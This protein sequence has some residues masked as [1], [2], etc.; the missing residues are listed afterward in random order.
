MEAHRASRP[1]TQVHFGR[2][3][4]VPELRLHR[5]HQLRRLR[6]PR[7]RPAQHR[8]V[9]TRVPH[10]PRLL[11]SGFAESHRADG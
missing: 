9:R 4:A 6:L 2:A 10:C 11:Q 8:H 3:R 5:R 1:P 7:S